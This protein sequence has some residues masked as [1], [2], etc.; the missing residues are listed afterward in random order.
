MV[1]DAAVVDDWRV[2]GGQVVGAAILKA[3]ACK[4][5]DGCLGVAG[6]ACK[7]DQRGLHL[8]VPKVETQ[9]DREIERHQCFGNVSCVI[10]RILELSERGIISP[11]ADDERNAS[12]LSCWVARN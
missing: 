2:N 3:M 7:P 10:D 11:V 1:C 9:P 6:G 4:E 8:D 12:E 5:H